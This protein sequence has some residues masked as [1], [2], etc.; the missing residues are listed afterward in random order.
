MN[1]FMD[2][3]RASMVG[4]ISVMVFSL[5]FGLF[6]KR[7]SAK[8]RKTGWILIAL[9][10]ILPLNLNQ[11]PDAETNVFT[12]KIPELVLR[13][14][15]IR[16]Q[17][18]RE[19]EK[20]NPVMD[21]GIITEQNTQS[22][23]NASAMEGRSAE[24]ASKTVRSEITT[25]TV[26]M[27]FWAF[28]AF[29]LTLYFGLGYWVLNRRYKR[30][31]SECEDE[32]ILNTALR[33]AGEYKLKKVPRIR[34][35]DD[36]G[37]GP[38]TIGLFKKI[39]YLPREYLI[40]DDVEYVLR[41]EMIHCKEHDLF[42][43]VFFVGVNIIHW[44]NPLV[45]MLRKFMDQDIEVICDETVVQ[46]ATMEERQEYGNVIMAWVERSQGRHQKNVFAT[47]YVSGSRFLKRRFDSIFDGSNKKQGNV[48]IGATVIVLVFLNCMIHV[49]AGTKLYLPSKIPIDE[50]RE[51]RTDVDGDGVVD[52]VYVLDTSSGSYYYTLV[53]A[54]LSSGHF[55]D[56]R[57]DE[58]V[59]G[60]HLIVGDLSGNGIADVV[61]MKSSV[62][63]SLRTGDVSVL[64]IVDGKWEEYPNTLIKNSS[65]DI[66]QPDNFSLDD[67]W[68]NWEGASIIEK[69]GKTLLRLIEVVSLPED[70]FICFDCSYREDGWYIESAEMIYDYYSAGKDLELL[71]W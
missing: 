64:H 70:K 48:M 35:M 4:G 38:L 33:I 23:Q 41:H 10:L 67:W 1:L 44:F 65:L 61:V 31:S 63:G 34:M 32:K 43:K 2:V 12:L 37:I 6:G 68:V 3:L 40:E 13:K 7:L 45:W 5:L 53:A 20:T 26:I 15:E 46:G 60:S 57:Y 24:T 51:V 50:G 62:G 8:H 39:V 58:D 27:L 49:E 11:L 55:A 9:C 22:T 28:T 42:W 66:E 59:Y 16:K 69:D 30:W 17:E 52:R 47:S 56:I 18:N 54:D 25:T 71:G 29:F 21:N 14:Q 19:D 36:S